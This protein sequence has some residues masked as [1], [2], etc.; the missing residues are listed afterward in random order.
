[1]AVGSCSAVP[2]RLPALEAAL[3]GQPLA[4][5]AD[6]V[7]PAH[8]APLAPIDDIRGTAAYRRHAALALVRDLLAE[9]ASAS[10]RR[11]A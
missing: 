7:A 1:V 11:A 8:L 10:R 9:L 2:Q 3:A 6:I 4:A 5:A